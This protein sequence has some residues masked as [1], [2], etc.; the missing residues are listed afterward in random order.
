MKLKKTFN[1]QYEAMEHLCKK[2]EWV[3][4]FDTI[5]APYY[6]TKPSTLVGLMER[7]KGYR[8]ERRESQGKV[9]GGTFVEYKMLKAPKRRAKR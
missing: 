9:W 5:K 8:F 4:L 1:N 6:I 7:E 3:G 2:K